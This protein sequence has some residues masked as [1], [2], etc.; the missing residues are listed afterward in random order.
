MFTGIK[1]LKEKGLV[2]RIEFRWARPGTG[3]RNRLGLALDYCL[4]TTS[5]IIRAASPAFS[6]VYLQFKK[7]PYALGSRAQRAHS[8]G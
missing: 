4:Q 7:G 2:D 5:G 8:T 1:W 3:L 6:R